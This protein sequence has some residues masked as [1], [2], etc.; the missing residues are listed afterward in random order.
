MTTAREINFLESALPS[1]EYT[2][3]KTFSQ[4]IGSMPLLKRFAQSE[5]NNSCMVAMNGGFV[6]E[7]DISFN[8]PSGLVNGLVGMSLFVLIGGLIASEP[9]SS[10]ILSRAIE[11]A[12]LTQVNAVSGLAD[13]NTIRLS[14]S[15]KENQVSSNKSQKSTTSTVSTTVAEPTPAPVAQPSPSREVFGFLPYWFVDSAADNLDFSLLTTLAY[16]D[17]PI[18]GDGSL[19]TLSNGWQKLQSP[20]AQD[21]LRRAT[22]SN[23]RVVLTYSSFDNEHIESIATN[24]EVRNSAVT[25]M[26]NFAKSQGAQGANIDFEYV[27]DP[28]AHVREGF[29][30][31]VEQAVER[32][33]AEIPSSQVTVSMYA[34]S[35]KMERLYQ[36]DRLADASD[37]LFIMAYDFY[38]AGSSNAGPVAP[39]TGA[40]D[41]YWYDITSSLNDFATAGVPAT[42]M[43]L[44]VPYY[45]YDWPTADHSPQSTV[46]PGPRNT[47]NYSGVQRVLAAGEGER[48]WDNVAQVPYLVY[49][50]DG[51]NRIAYYDDVESLGKKYDLVNERNLKGAGIWALGQDGDHKELWDLLRTKFIHE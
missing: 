42:K 10:A 18:N 11:A 51:V 4:W 46:L 8:L 29:S 39:L 33:H 28:D 40:P 3:P 45:G 25:N 36:V 21:T 31:F 14:L 22:S 1:E 16:F 5:V 26:V 30:N 44:G 35:A 2:K 24:E 41:T 6:F 17:I 12:R 7:Q 47:A 50:E 9:L 19:D 15:P 27:G 23:V 34:I 48:R 20:T 37:G 32:F 43:I 38:T 13:G 49:Q